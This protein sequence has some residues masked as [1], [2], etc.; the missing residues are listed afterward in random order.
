M[1]DEEGGESR[2]IVPDGKK[3]L[4]TSIGDIESFDDALCD[5]TKGLPIRTG[6]VTRVASSDYHRWG[7]G[8]TEDNA[9]ALKDLVEWYRLKDMREMERY[10]EKEF[11]QATSFVSGLRSSMARV[12]AFI[13]KEMM[14]SIDDGKREFA[15][16]D[17]AAGRGKAST[18]IAAA[19]RSDE[20][21]MKILERTVFHLVDFSAAKLAQ[22]Q[23]GLEIYSPKAIKTH[24]RSDDEFFGETGERFDLVVSLAHLHKK[25]FPEIYSSISNALLE[26]G[27]LV[28]GDWHSSM[29]QHPIFIYQLLERMN[30][31]ARRLD[32][33]RSLMCEFLSPDSS[34][35]LSVEEIRAISD[36]QEYWTDVYLDILQSSSRGPRDV[37]FYILGAFDT[38]KSRVE[39]ME[40][41]G[42]ETDNG[43]IRAAFPEAKLPVLPKGLINGAD[44]ASITVGIRPR[45][46]G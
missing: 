14:L 12:M 22:A 36:H 33:F 3:T 28:S 31:E 38:T 20:V 23:A 1:G 25:S 34:P 15:V 18:A 17:L 2:I 30:I 24:A 44:R 32:M 6:S 27:A 9:W 41:A 43:R 16:C 8:L 26:N 42:L 7:I 46:T 21:S 4:L 40:A 5:V 45:R 10:P 19:L 37:R 13:I 39:K 11:V 29:C 35:A